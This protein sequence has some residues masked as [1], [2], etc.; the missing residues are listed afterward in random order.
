[1]IT[2][3]ELEGI[4][5]KMLSEGV[6][7]GV[8][9]RVFSLDLD[10]VK[11]TQKQVRTNKYGTDD[12]ND[13]FEQMVWDTIEWARTT[14]ATGSAAD[15]SRVGTAILGKQMTAALRRAPQGDRDAQDEWM[16]VFKKMRGA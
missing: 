14:M 2:A 4:V 11:A 3:D 10:L 1:M 13:Y 8:V 9:S 16:D 6:P 7:A 12:Q 15:Q 5:E